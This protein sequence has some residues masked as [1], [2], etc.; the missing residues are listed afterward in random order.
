[1]IAEAVAEAVAPLK[2]RIVELEAKLACLSKNSTTSSKPPSSDIVKPPRK[3]TSGGRR[4]K[5]RAGG[6][7]GHA[8]HTRPA[9]PPEQV[10]ETWDYEWEEVPAGWKA[11][12]RFHIL[13][14]VELVEKTYL[15][16]EHRAR[17]YKNLLTGQVLAARLPPE[18]RRSGLLGP[19]LTALVAYRKGA[20]HMSVETIRRFPADVFRLPI[21]HGQVLKTVRRATLAF[22]PC[23]EQLQ[24]AGRCE[25]M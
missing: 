9:F 3:P 10:D 1:M 13:Q 19:R 5:R 14:Q 11:L 2:A 7:P 20:C 16:T 23:Y 24:E 25:T 6:Q 12:D 4:G 21:S 17:L 15:V 18:V 8:R 22:G